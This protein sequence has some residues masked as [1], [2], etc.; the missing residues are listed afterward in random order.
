MA[1]CTITF[2]G[3]SPACPQSLGPAELQGGPS[4]LGA[5]VLSHLGLLATLPV[6]LLRETETHF[7]YWGSLAHCGWNCPGVGGKEGLC[8]LWKQGHALPQC[9]PQPLKKASGLKLLSHKRELWPRRAKCTDKTQ[10]T[11]RSSTRTP[12]SRARLG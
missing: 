12:D 5:Q 9:S 6:W 11:S 1:P 3:S 4:R 10:I 7:C 8:G 2:A